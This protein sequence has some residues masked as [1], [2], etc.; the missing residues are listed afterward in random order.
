MDVKDTPQAGRPAGAAP[1][2]GGYYLERLLSRDEPLDPRVNALRREAADGLAADRGGWPNVS[3]A[4]ALLIRNTADLALI[5]GTIADY[6]FRREPINEQGE[7]L[8]ILR[9][10]FVGYSNALRRHLEALGLDRRQPEPQSL[11]EYLRERDQALRATSGP[12]SDAAA[13]VAIEV[14]SDKGRNL[15]G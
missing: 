4:E 12:Q 13:A 5:T 11:A 6:V 9:K 10:M 1:S 8:P 14:P 2:H 7:A 15:G 3:N